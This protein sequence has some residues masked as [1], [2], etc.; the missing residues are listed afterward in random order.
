MAED[1]AVERIVEEKASLYHII[2]NGPHGPHQPMQLGMEQKPQQAHDIPP[3]RF[4]NTAGCG[5]IENEHIRLEFTCQN[6]SL[7]LALSHPG[8]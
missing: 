1:R 5:I 3:L 8:S 2:E 4:C 7:S 6:D